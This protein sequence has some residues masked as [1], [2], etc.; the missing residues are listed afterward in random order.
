MLGKT[1]SLYANGGLLNGRMCF[2]ATGT[3]QNRR[4]RF[5]LLL[6]RLDSQQT[7]RCFIDALAGFAKQKLR[8]LLKI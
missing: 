1:K 2:G 7:L 6:C 8:I 3:L 4:Q 5:S